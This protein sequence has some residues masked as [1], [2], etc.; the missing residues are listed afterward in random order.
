MLYNFVPFLVLCLLTAWCTLMFSWPGVYLLLLLGW[1]LLHGVVV[2]WNTISLLCT[3]LTR[4]IALHLST[5]MPVFYSSQFKYQ[6]KLGSYQEEYLVLV[7]S[8]ISLDFVVHTS[9]TWQQFSPPLK[10]LDSHRSNLSFELPQKCNNQIISSTTPAMYN[11]T[12]F[13]W[14]TMGRK[15]NEQRRRD[16]S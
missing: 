10:T 8:F 4:F 13:C 16:T 14:V 7:V 15:V 11:N 3:L 12:A 9:S 6:Q 2:R 1:F 5:M